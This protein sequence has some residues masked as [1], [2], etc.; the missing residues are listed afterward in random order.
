MLKLSK[1]SDAGTLLAVT[2]YFIG[3]LPSHFLG[4]DNTIRRIILCDYFGTSIA[5]AFNMATIIE[6][7]SIAS[8]L[9]SCTTVAQSDSSCGNLKIFKTPTF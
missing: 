4:K 6:Y 7:V 5:T 3:F 9:V 8:F 2:F 1:I